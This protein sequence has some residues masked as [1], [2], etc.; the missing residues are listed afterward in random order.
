MIL[1]EKN[2]HIRDEQISFQEKGHI[3]T[4]NGDSSFLSVTTWIKT[5][6]EEFDADKII[7]K[8]MNSRN[9]KNSKYYGKTKKQIK[10]EWNEQGKTASNLGTKLHEDIEKYYNQ[11]EF[12]NDSVE[13]KYFLNFIN[14]FPEFK[15]Y[16]S[17]WKVWDANLRLSGSIDMVF[18]HEDNLVIVDW[19]RSKEIK[20]EDN[21][22][23][24]STSKLLNHINDLNFWHYSLQLNTYKALLERNYDKQIYNMFILCLH[25]SNQNY[26]K[27]DI[28]DLQKEISM[29]F[30]ERENSF[31]YV[32]EKTRDGEIFLVDENNN[33]YNE[34]GEII[35]TWK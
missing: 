15:P 34:D 27:F 11:Q 6:F 3:Y 7:N 1:E 35:G 19:K 22:N 13:F 20:K 33:I 5:F 2:K 16:R 31:V 25:P 14:D 10:D 32:E 8:M 12:N 18:E 17:E 9:W 21:W 4:V 29:L 26:I 24:K 30:E 23:K 28:P